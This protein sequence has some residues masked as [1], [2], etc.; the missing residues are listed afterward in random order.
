MKRKTKLK[1]KRKNL[2]ILVIIILLILLAN[3]ITSIIKLKH[4]G[5][6]I[7]SSYLIYKKGIKKEVLEENYSKTL[8]SIIDSDYFDKEKLPV[9]FTIDYYD[10]EKFN[11]NISNFINNKYTAIDI[12]NLNKR[13][14][15]TLNKL[16]TETYINDISNYLEYSYFKTDKLERYL[17]YFNGDYENTIISVNIGL[18]KKF[19]EDANIIKEYSKDVLVNKYNKLDSSFEPKELTKLTKCSTGEE[20]LSKE[21]KEAYDELCDASIKDG[22]SIGIT[23]SYRS[24][25]NQQ[26]TYNYYLKNNGQDYV[27][28]YVAMPGYSEHQTGLAIDVKSTNASPFK[29]TKE[30]KWMISNAYKYGFI[31]RYPENKETITG[32]NPEAWHFRYVGK[33]IANYINEKN[34]TYDEY[35]A[36]F[37]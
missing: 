31:L 28:K 15:E 33:E 30:Y 12:N 19:Y 8:E 11:E 9:Y 32:Y 37:M 17:A 34:I 7:H 16:V 5:Y 14:D 26:D 2:I 3:P 4:K 6:S 18:D 35:C 20:Y 10:Y 29:S 36:I 13:N 21:A 25:K 23:S 22:M 24:Y 1:V 27:D